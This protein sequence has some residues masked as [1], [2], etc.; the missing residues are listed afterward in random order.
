MIPAG[1][2]LLISEMTTTGFDSQ[3]LTERLCDQIRRQGPMTFRDW[4]ESAL[5]DKAQGYYCRKDLARWG[6]EGD[7]RTSPETTL[8]FAATFARYFAELFHDAGSPTSFTLVEVGGGAGH[9]ASEL[10]ETLSRRFPRVFDAITYVF[11]EVSEDSRDRAAERLVSFHDKVEFKQLSRLS[12]FEPGIVF[13]NELLDAFPI[14]RVTLRGGILL[15]L[16][17]GLGDN[18]RFEWVEGPPSTPRLAAFLER[19]QVQLSEGQIAEV[20][21]G[22]EDW[23][24]LV[25][26]KLKCGY[27]VTVDYGLAATEL[28]D[29]L[30]RR[31]GTLRAFLRHEFAANVLS[32]PGEQDIT[33]SVDWTAAM[34]LGRGLGFESCVFDRQDRFLLRCGLL[35]ELELRVAQEAGEGEKMRLRTSVRDMILPGGMASSFQVLVQ[36]RF[37]TAQT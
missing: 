31:N 13:S 37:R 32:L 28:Y 21:L 25:S 20:N 11:D 23:F 36:R 8:L 33:S 7:Y 26:Q 19:F 9:F 6:R 15:E 30:A 14:H 4:M 3:T 2:E 5:Y 34:S 35:E 1:F 22:L 17:V 18:S 16:Y 29:S 12:A 24:G 10:L 27:L